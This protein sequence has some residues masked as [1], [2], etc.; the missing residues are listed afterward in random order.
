MSSTGVS[1]SSLLAI[2]APDLSAFFLSIRQLTWLTIY[3]VRKRKGLLQLVDDQVI[4][5]KVTKKLFKHAA[6]RV[7]TDRF[8]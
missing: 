5:K 3:P 1:F 6:E 4:N 7:R 2:A 8:Y